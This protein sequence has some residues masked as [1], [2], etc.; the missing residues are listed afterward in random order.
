MSD[1]RPFIEL[2]AGGL[3]PLAAIDDYVDVWHDGTDPRALHAFL[4]M[5]TSE[6][7]MWVE[8]PEVLQ[9]IVWVRQRNLALAPAQDG[10]SRAA[11]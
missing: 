4:G 7:A 6:Y 3:V 9:F 1:C 10:E 11:S 5:T 8:H 2:C